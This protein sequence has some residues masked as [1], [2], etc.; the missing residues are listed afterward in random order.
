MIVKLTEEGEISQLAC[1]MTVVVPDFESDGTATQEIVAKMY[2]K[3][4]KLYVSVPDEQGNITKTYANLDDMP[5]YSN[6]LNTKDSFNFESMLKNLQEALDAN[7]TVSV[8]EEGTT[9]KYKVAYH[10]DEEN[11]SDEEQ[12]DV[13]NFVGDCEIFIVIEDG[14]FVGY[15]MNQII[16]EK[17]VPLATFVKFD[18]EIEFPDFSSYVEMPTEAKTIEE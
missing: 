2:I 17:T 3:D 12:S 1:K 11:Q 6:Y 4:G 8:F 9:V 14:V 5:E 7:A 13:L 16:D 10:I 18:E 15:S